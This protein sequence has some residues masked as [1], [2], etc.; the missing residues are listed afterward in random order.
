[1]SVVLNALYYMLY[2]RNVMSAFQFYNHIPGL[3]DRPL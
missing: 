2:T 3:F 1:M